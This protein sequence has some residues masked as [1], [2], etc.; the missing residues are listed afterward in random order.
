[1]ITFLKT[2]AKAFFQLRLS[3]SNQ[4]E[5]GMDTKS[6]DINSK[7]DYKISYVDENNNYSSIL[8]RIIGFTLS[9]R[10][11][12]KSFVNY[13]IKGNCEKYCCVDTIKV[14][15]SEDGHSSVRTINVR[16]I[17]D[18]VSYGGND[19]E[20]VTKIKEFR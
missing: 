10:P 6:F 5:K 3:I 15:C 19:F 2:D 12:P 7:Y 16:D 20:D 14:D 18:I 11:D 17:R 4:G 13:D 8:C 1:M 9:N